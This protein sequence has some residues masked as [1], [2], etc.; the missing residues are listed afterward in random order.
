MQKLIDSRWLA[1][2]LG[3]LLIVPGAALFAMLNLNIEP[4]FG[5]FEPYLR[6]SSGDAP[7]IVG[8]LIAFNAIVV[9]PLVALL[10]N[11]APAIRSFRDRENSARRRANLFVA[12]AAVFVV[13]MFFGA[14]VVDQYPCWAGVPN[15]D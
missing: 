1:A 3:A 12:A 10:L 7:H 5:P 14:I 6:R 8:S 13:L 4:P 15:C 11:F 2:V 9:F